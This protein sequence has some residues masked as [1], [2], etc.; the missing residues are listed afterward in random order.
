MEMVMMPWMET[1]LYFLMPE[2]Q[3]NDICLSDTAQILV[4]NSTLPEISMP[5][6]W[7]ICLLTA[8]ALEKHVGLEISGRIS[9]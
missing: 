7:K 2:S 1:V 4:L 6:N 9:L 5:S 3:S 8:G